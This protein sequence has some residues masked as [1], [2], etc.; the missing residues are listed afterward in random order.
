MNKKISILL[1][2]L[3]LVMAYGGVH[4]QT[5][6]SIWGFSLSKN[7]IKQL[8]VSIENEEGSSQYLI[9]NQ[10]EVSRIGKLLSK[11]EQYS[12]VNSF[13]LD[14]QPEKYTQILIQMH[15]NT[16]YGGDLWVMGMN[17]VQNSNGYYWKVDYEK[18]SALLNEAIPA[19]EKV[20]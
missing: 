18:L 15:D 6:I 13:S 5:H 10:K 17:Y 4:S 12:E 2:P 16:T 3:I 11:S 7:D 1:I 20:Q 19:G 9:T 8:I 14:E